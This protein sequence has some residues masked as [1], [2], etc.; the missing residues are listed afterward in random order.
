MTAVTS[1]KN[2]ETNKEATIRIL[3]DTG[4]RKA[5]LRTE[6][7]KILGLEVLENQFFSVSG[8]AQNRGR[9]VCTPLVSFGLKLQNQ[10]YLTI[11]ANLSQ[12]ITRPIQFF[13]LDIECQNLLKDVQL[14]DPFVNSDKLGQIDLLLGMEYFWEIIDLKPPRNLTKDIKLLSSKLGFLPVG[15]LFVPSS[16]NYEQVVVMFLSDIKVPDETNLTLELLWKLEM[17]GIRESG[18]IKDDDIAQ[19][20][21]N[22]TVKFLPEK[23]RYQVQFPKRG[24]YT[25]LPD[26]YRLALGRLKSLLRRLRRS[27]SEQI[28]QLYDGVFKEQLKL[29]IIEQVKP[30]APPDGYIH[31][32]PHHA[33]VD[34][35]RASTKCRVV[36]DASAKMSTAYKSLNENLYRGPVDLEDL[37]GLLFRFREGQ[38]ALTSDIEKAFL[39]IIVHPCDRDMT[40]LIW[41]K[42]VQNP[43]F[44]ADNLIIYRIVRVNFGLVCSPFLLMAVIRHHMNRPDIKCPLS[45]KI[46]RNVY[47]DNVMLSVDSPSE[48]LEVY[49]NAKALFAKAGMNLRQWSANSSEFIDQLPL[50]DRGVGNDQKVLGIRW[51]LV[52]DKIYIKNPKIKHA[53][54]NSKRELC[55]VLGSFFDPL[56]FLSPLIAPLK[57]IVQDLWKLKLSWDAP[58]PKNIQLRWEKFINGLGDISQIK[59]PRFIGATSNALSVQLHAFCDASFSSYATVVYIRIETTEKV[60]VA[61]LFAKNRLA[62]LKELT[63]PRLE[64]M[65]ALIAIRALSFVLA[66]I[67]ISISNCYLWTDS[68]CVIGWLRTDKILPVWVRNRV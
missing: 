9:T 27:G 26:N 16:L 17:L 39:Q 46:T 19:A 58:L 43:S 8:F 57:L 1:I 42:D 37:C 48:A 6:I 28:L 7:A 15:K 67:D 45:D 23:G 65:G 34:L 56:G 12:V 14:A 62:P 10:N 47:V 49:K 38:I 11:Y 32:I 68:E 51:D 2:F 36:Y 55:Q 4:S 29:G 60:T 41:V 64:L 25:D 18:L 35:E 21:F 33:V 66:Q 24:Q 3:F 30:T 44:D 63:L 54:V 5:F 22:K 61:L 13:P 50:A 20:E 59:I 53:T 40:R 31:Y 52:T